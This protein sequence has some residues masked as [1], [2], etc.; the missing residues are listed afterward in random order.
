MFYKK[1]FLGNFAK[2]TGKHLW[3]RDSG[4]GAF[5][6]ISRN[7]EEHLFLQNTSGGCFCFLGDRVLWIGHENIGE[8]S[9]EEISELL[10][11]AH[12][13]IRLVVARETGSTENSK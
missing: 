5:L 6:W 2:F 7:F 11:D 10:K 13:S 1:V 3:Q 12:L 4:T 8:M 9:K